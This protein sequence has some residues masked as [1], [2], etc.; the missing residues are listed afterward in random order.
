MSKY[1][2]FLNQKRLTKEEYYEY[3]K[4]N[5]KFTDELYPPNDF[6]IYSQTLNGEFRDKRAGK[7][8]KDTLDSLLTKDSKKFTIEWERISDR[9]YF[10]KIYNEKISHEQIEQ[11]SLGDCYLIS[12]IASI[13]HFPDLIIGKKD[14]DTPH[15]LYNYEYGDIGYYELMFFIDGEYKIVIIDDYIPF[16]K[17]KGITIFANSSENYFWVNLVEKAYS[18]ICGGYTSIDLIS[19]SENKN[20]ETYDYFQVFT[21]FKYEKFNFYDEKDGQFIL[22]KSKVDSAIKIIENNLHKEKGK[23]FNTMITTGTPDEKKGLYLEENFIPYQHSFSIL[24]FKKIKINK[25][26]SEIKLL[27]LNN[28][29]GRNIYNEGVGSYC[30]ENLDENVMNLKPYIEYN[31]NSE[32]GCFWIDYDS[33]LKNYISIN[34]CKIPCNYNCI[35]FSL[36]SKENFELP[37]IYKLKIDKK[38][39]IFFNVNMSISEEIRSGND[40]IYLMKFLLISKIDEKGKIIKTYNEIIGL[41]D[42]QINYDLDEGNYIIWLYIPKRYFPESDKLDA[43]FMV[44]SEHKIKFGF[45][46]YDI[47]FKYI[48]SLSEYWFEQNNQERLKAKEEKMVKC[49]V[50]CKSVDGILIVY[51]EN[52]TSDKKIICEPESECSGFSPINYKENINLLKINATLFPGE[53]VFYIGISTSKKSIFSINKINMQYS[54][55]NEKRENSK[56]INFNEYLNK[57][58]NKSKKITSVKYT[59]NSYC[60]IRTNFNKN[61]DKRDEDKIF[62]YFL[63]LMTEKLKSKKL[64]QDKIKLITKNTWDKMK[65]SDKEKIIKKYEQKKKELKNTVL[66]MQVLKYIK[67]NSLSSNNLNENKMDNEIINMKIKTRLN[68]EFQFVKFEDDLDELEKKIKIILPKIDYLKSTEKDEVELDKYIDK[69]NEITKELKKLLDEKI[70]IE[71]GEQIDKKKIA[72]LKEYEPLY[73]KMCEY[74]KKHD[75]NMKLFNEINIEGQ[76]LLKEVKEQVDIYNTKKLNLK[77]ELNNLID[78]FMNFMEEIKKLK[79]VQINEKC[80]REVK[81]AMEFFEDV[82]KMQTKIKTFIDDFND[83]IKTQQNEILPKE[84]QESIKKIQNELTDNL[85]KLKE[86]EN[87][88]KFLLS[89]I[90]EE[91]TLI[92]NCEILEKNIT[93]ENPKELLTKLQ[94]YE[95]Q[96]KNLAEKINKFQGDFKKIVESYNN[97]IK[98]RN[99]IGKQIKEIFDKFKE[100]KV[101]NN[102]DFKSLVDK[103][104]ELDKGFKGLKINEII[105]KN[106][107]ELLANWTR[108]NNAFNNSFDKFEQSYGKKSSNTSSKNT[109]ISNNNLSNEKI[110]E[111]KDKVNKEMIILEKEQKEIKNTLDKIKNDKKKLIE[112]INNLKKEEEK[113]LTEIKK[114]FNNDIK[115][116][117]LTNL[118]DNFE[119]YK[120]FNEKYQEIGQKLNDITQRC[121]SLFQSYNSFIKVE[122]ENR[123]KIY[124]NA[125]ILPENGIN[126]DEKIEK[127]LKTLKEIFDDIET[128]NLD[129]LNGLINNNAIAKFKEIQNII[130]IVSQISKK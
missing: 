76:S 70:T 42:L 111:I 22:N 88:Y 14:A 60:Y 43:H 83:N 103:L 90:E 58:F 39:N 72:L 110:K 13:S 53:H 30:L 19:L 24:D 65:D 34:V 84:K 97:Y 20:K 126:V 26:K 63:S 89:L 85:S 112:D 120:A 4:Q 54:E 113:S 102:E 95:K 123:K 106:K 3:Q 45:I 130:S 6:S 87:D 33:F 94:N 31:L 93:K 55:T 17:E 59:T 96:I 114:V 40:T 104:N 11:G 18:K 77:K 28:P 32:D 16:V 125:K 46:D 101:P 37:L 7:L 10:N 121:K 67:R 56:R 36:N 81:K 50:D 62:E 69:Q 128:L 9:P 5:K 92:K 75:E 98:G 47:D 44:S 23:K 12:L 27:L 82:K 79:L 107:N 91:N 100:K 78:K 99:E 8:S 80:N 122:S 64:S 61:P 115:N 38:T 51:L 57:E 2:T 129:E 116:I 73:K 52:N 41:D 25:G 49:I 21:G 127:I 35:N 119:K 71:T 124:D 109:N 1:S 29:W 15:I 117:T 86:T 66:K 68:H 74:F 118:K 48:K 108:V 105:E